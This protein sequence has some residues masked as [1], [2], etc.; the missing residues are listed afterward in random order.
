MTSYSYKTISST[1]Y[2]GHINGGYPSRCYNSNFLDGVSQGSSANKCEALCSMYAVCIAY[3]FD[4]NTHC[5]LMTSTGTCPVG[6]ISPG[7]VA[8]KIP[9]L[10]ASSA[11][12]YSCIAKS[13]YK[14]IS[15]T[16][17]CGHI[18]GGYPSRCY[19]TNLLDGVSQG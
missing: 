18:N 11:S 6:S 12:G 3:S 15:S 13:Q 10:T 14:T 5:A 19:S 8:N 2:C 16:H 1:H 4:G 9:Q 7:I 17:Y